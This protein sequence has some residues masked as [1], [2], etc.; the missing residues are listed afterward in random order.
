MVFLSCTDLLSKKHCCYLKLAR[1][2]CVIHNRDNPEKYLQ[3]KN[4][5]FCWD[6]AVCSLSNY[7]LGFC[8]QLYLFCSFFKFWKASNVSISL[9][10]SFLSFLVM[11]FDIPSLEFGNLDLTES[12]LRLQFSNDNDMLLFVRSFVPACI[13]TT[14]GFFQISDFIYLPQ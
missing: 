4:Y 3:D 8:Y 11:T 13:I 2:F 6:G 5:L 7:H 10:I 14:S 1:I 12:V 9:S